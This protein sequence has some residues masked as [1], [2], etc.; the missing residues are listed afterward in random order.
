MML[1]ASPGRWV[2]HQHQ[3]LI[4]GNGYH[5]PHP[6]LIRTCLT[7]S[8][9]RDITRPRIGSNDHSTVAE[10][11]TVLTSY[12]IVQTMNTSTSKPQECRGHDP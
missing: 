2:E 8:S 1:E 11:I 7:S 4:Y 5:V 6:Y 3:L 12:A 9:D 10:A